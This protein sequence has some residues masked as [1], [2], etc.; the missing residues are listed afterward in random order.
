MVGETKNPPRSYH[1][2]IGGITSFKAVR[3]ISRLPALRR[4]RLLRSAPALRQVGQRSAGELR[5]FCVCFGLQL[6][7]G[8]LGL[9]HAFR[10]GRRR[11]T[12]QPASIHQT[13]YVL[14]ST[15]PERMQE[16][17]PS[18]TLRPARKKKG[19]ERVPCPA[20]HRA[21]NAST[22]RLRHGTCRRRSCREWASPFPARRLLLPRY[23]SSARRKCAR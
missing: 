4:G 16:F 12:G 18:A 9:L 7:Y 6:L 15:T 2:A 3:N 23:P 11:I 10:E 19:R 1:S 21:K 5:R 14:Y 17:S 8:T 22:A 20:A 13:F